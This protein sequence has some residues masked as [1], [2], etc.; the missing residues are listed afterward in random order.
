M[1]ARRKVSFSLVRRSVDGVADFLVKWGID[2]DVDETLSW[3]LRSL[4]FF[5]GF[6]FGLQG[7]GFDVFWFAFAFLGFLL[8]FRLFFFSRFKSRRPF[9]C[10]LSFHQ[11]MSPL[12]SL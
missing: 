12:L 11:Y 6:Y 7:R 10:T 3:D 9:S 4:D 8:Y 2:R 1:C 5:E